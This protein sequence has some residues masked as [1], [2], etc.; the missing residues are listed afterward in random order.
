LAL[1]ILVIELRDGNALGEFDL[2]GVSR[3]H[4]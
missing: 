1:L 2:L 3:W 4:K